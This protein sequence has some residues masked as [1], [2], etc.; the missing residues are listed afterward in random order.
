MPLRART[1]RASLGTLG[2]AVLD[3]GAQGLALGFAQLAV[4]IGIKTLNQLL[5]LAVG[6]AAVTG[7][8][9]TG[10]TLRAVSALTM[11]A[12]ATHLGAGGS[13]FFIAQLA[14][15]IRV[16][17]FQHAPPNVLAH[18]GAIFCA[19]VTAGH[20]TTGSPVA[21][22]RGYRC[23]FRL[24]GILSQYGKRDDKRRDKCILHYIVSVVLFFIG[25]L[26]PLCF[27]ERIYISTVYNYL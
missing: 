4:T 8:R 16:K 17:S 9:I 14:V 3:S 13:S 26:P 7:V 20:H 27:K 21:G 5:T 15:F 25:R 2:A 23:T 1:A 6:A 12:A 24:R 22:L 10:G 11:R 19:H 18:S